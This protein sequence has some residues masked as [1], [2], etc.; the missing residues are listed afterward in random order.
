MK[1]MSHLVD[2]FKIN[3]LKLILTLISPVIGLYFGYILNT[4]G[5]GS[6]EIIFSKLYLENITNTIEIFTSDFRIEYLYIMI[7]ILISYYIIH[8]LIILIFKPIF[9]Y[10]SKILEEKNL[11]KYLFSKRR[12]TIL[13]VLFILYSHIFI[14]IYFNLDIINAVAGACTMGIPPSCMYSYDGISLAF[15]TSI[16]LVIVSHIILSKF[17]IK[18]NKYY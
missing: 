15:Y 14:K 8:S 18:G 5:R 12:G 16:V 1:C 13:F 17:L 6:K 2:S 10:L 11:D 4:I 9:M 7:G 3:K